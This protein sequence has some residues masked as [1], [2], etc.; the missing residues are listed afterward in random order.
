MIFV[1]DWLILYPYFLILFYV[2]L[3]YLPSPIPGNKFKMISVSTCYF[4]VIIS[5]VRYGLI[6]YMLDNWN[7]FA[8]MKMLIFYFSR[9]DN[10]EEGQV[11]SLFNIFR[12]VLED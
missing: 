1:G 11:Y 6:C 8:E 7:A 2:L 3:P 9:M 12:C 4:G 5:C 10:L